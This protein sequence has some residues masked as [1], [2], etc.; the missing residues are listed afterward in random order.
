MSRDHA[1]LKTSAASLVNVSSS[2]VGSC[3]PFVHRLGQAFPTLKLFLE[4]RV[5]SPDYHGD[6]TVEAFVQYLHLKTDGTV[7]A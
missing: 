5:Q 6:R 3:L 4:D 7:S 2:R 1:M